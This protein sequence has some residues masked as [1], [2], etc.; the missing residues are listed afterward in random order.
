M[1]SL[2]SAVWHTEFL[3]RMDFYRPAIMLL[4]DVSLDF[5]MARRSRRLIEEIM[6]QA[7]SL[8][9]TCAL[10]SSPLGHQRR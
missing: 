4:A 2:L 6:P 8:P 10:Y 3:G 5:E 1:D 9:T 7:S